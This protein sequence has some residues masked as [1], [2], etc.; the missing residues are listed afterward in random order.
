MC[1]AVLVSAVIG[2]LTPSPAAAATPPSAPRGL[3]ASAGPGSGQVTLTWTTPSSTGGSTITNFGYAKSTDGGATFSAVIWFNSTATSRSSNQVPALN[4]ST[5]ANQKGCRY[6]VFARNAA[7]TSV[8]SN[9]VTTWVVPSAPGNFRGTIDASYSTA[10]LKWDRPGTSGAFTTLTYRLLRSVDGGPYAETTTTTALGKSVGC[11][12]AT[13]CA[14]KIYATNGQGNGPTT[15]SAVTF[16]VAPSAVVGL[17]VANTASNRGTG[18]SNLS[19]TWSRPT[20]GLAVDHYEVQQ[21]GTPAAATGA[22]GAGAWGPVTNVTATTTSRTSTCSAGVASCSVMVR[23]VNTRG[24]AGPASIVNLRPWAPFD[25][26]ATRS[27]TGKATVRFRGPNDSGTGTPKS[28]SV[29]VCAS[30]CGNA[31]NWADSGLTVG[32]PRTDAAPHTAG[33][34]TCAGTCQVRMQFT[35]GSA[36]S[37]LTPAVSGTGGSVATVTITTPAHGAHVAA[38][39][40]AVTGTCSGALGGEVTAVATG[41][42]TSTASAPCSASGSWQA[43][44]GSLAPG[45][46]LLDASQTDAGGNTGTP[47]GQ[48][49]FHVD[50][51]AAGTVVADVVAGGL[52]YPAMFS[53][54]SRSRIFFGELKTGEINIFDP[55]NGTASLF[56]SVGDLCTAGDQGLFGVVPH[57]NYPSDPSVYAYASRLQSG[58]CFNQLLRLTGADPLSPGGSPTTE[59]LFSQQYLGEHIGGRLR[60]RTGWVALPVDGRGWRR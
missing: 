11:N 15:A 19:T 58:I 7:G 50:G 9:T 41:P 3:V 55:A 2:S 1:G 16:G 23:A 17:A 30:T 25:V 48:R 21:C 57:P 60:V 53:F 20:S 27:G 40:V 45:A 4:C 38:A 29:F 36:K 22:C 6:R 49:T 47:A 14:Y 39:P 32:H 43:T 13:T 24:G 10:I 31:S 8:A 54:D 28:Y 56:A 34:V 52:N 26:T 33:Q 12:G 37:V 51:A 46:Y 42:N 5:R 44:F 18:V 35:A 59:V